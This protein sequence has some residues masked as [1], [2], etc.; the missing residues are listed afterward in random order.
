MGR[1][2]RRGWR[3]AGP[4][5]A[6]LMVLSGCSGVHITFDH[7]TPTPTPSSTAPT[8]ETRSPSPDP[9]TA[10]PR[11]APTLKEAFTR[12]SPGVVRLEVTT[13]DGASVGSGFVVGSHLVATVAHVVD[14]GQ[15][16]RVV[17]G[18]KA[19]AGRVL[20]IDPGTDV[21]LVRTTATMDGS[22]LGFSH[23][24]VM[25]GD[26]VAALGFPEGDPLSY[27]TGTVNGLDRKAV[28]S[29]TARHDLIEIDAATNPGS[30]GG[31]VIRADGKVIG[32]VDAGPDDGA[33][34]RLAVGGSV[35]ED[36]IANWR[37]DPDPPTV[38]PCSSLS[39]PDGSGDL[40]DPTDDVV[41]AVGTLEI[42]F[43]SING[44]DFPTAY[45]QFFSQSGFKTFKRA[46]TSSQD[47]DL[48]LTGVSTDGAGGPV[49]GLDFTS[50]QDAGM[51]P[52]GRPDETCTNWSL[53]YHFRQRDGLWLISGSE[54]HDGVSRSESC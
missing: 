24:K 43:R 53:D 32:L 23:E 34:R 45:A 35:A 22:A 4:L 13:C 17:Q 26:E 52:A 48:R 51:G 20:G 7:P 1:T 40:S 10:S 28:V 49:V 9:T 36:A 39:G 30:S 42:Y 6:G 14:Q 11:P 47:T 44:G 18:T 8:A 15:V 25:V 31:P 5:A 3:T 2:K 21:A 12:V 16:I 38:E 41:E 37:E 33:G 19:T 29:G 54:P 46:V 27:N 50:H